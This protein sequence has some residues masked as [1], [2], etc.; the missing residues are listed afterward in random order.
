M[1]TAGTPT[2]GRPHV[3]ARERRAARTVALLSSVPKPLAVILAVGALQSI[4]W[5]LVTPAFQGPDEVAH[6]AYVQYLAETGHL[7]RA[8]QAQLGEASLLA[9]GSTEQQDALTWLNLQPTIK[10]PN[11]KPAWTAADRRLWDRIERS[12]PRGSR[13]NGGASNTIA[14]N[15]PLYYAVMAV[16]YRAFVWLPLL[17]RVFVLR[18]FNALFFLAT[19]ALSWL[20]AG[21]LFGQVR[22]KQALTA[23]AVALEPQLAFMSSVINADN[24]LIALT[25]GVLLA[26]LVLVRRGP[27]VARALALSVAAAAAVLTHG[28]GLVTLPVVIVALAVAWIKHR[29]PKRDTFSVG[30][31]G[32]VPIGAAFLAYFLFARGPGTSALYGGQIGQLNS[33]TGFKLGQFL[34]GVWNFYFH[35]FAPLSGS[36]DPGFGYRQ[37]FIEPF[38]GGFGSLDVHLPK[39]L[40]GLMQALS[41]LGLVGLCAAVFVRRRQLRSSWPVVVVMLALFLTTMVFL[42]YVSYRALAGDGGKDPLI[43]GRYLLPM[44]A[45]FGVAITF[46][47]GAL[48]RRWRPIMGAAVLSIGVLLCLSGIGLTAF[49]FYA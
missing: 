40:S 25:T 49:R 39:S 31:A 24:L 34:S 46:T 8:P 22:W 7:P 26:A 18:L 36:L 1:A 9:L 15:P 19:I 5:N 48:P 12:A 21:E 38:Y 28:R 17:K 32:L 3:K 16:P 35:K 4:A 33:A 30:A 20:I 44:I 13:A 2:L 45:L 10:N 43:T 47:V 37:V 6:F 27:S 14:K 23:G 11:S 29:P 41:A 42:H